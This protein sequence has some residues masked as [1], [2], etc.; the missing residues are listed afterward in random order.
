MLGII[1]LMLIV[2]Y[3]LQTEAIWMA[4][5]LLTKVYNIPP[6]RLYVTYFEGNKSLELG[7]DEQTRDIW[8][9]LGYA[10]YPFVDFHRFLADSRCKKMKV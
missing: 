8:L 4:W 5:E 6:D 2:S 1:V 10:Y 9:D 3:V 7:P